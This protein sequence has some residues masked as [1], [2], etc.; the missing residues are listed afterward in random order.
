[1]VNGIIKA[2]ITISY[3]LTTDARLLAYP[4]TGTIVSLDHVAQ[5]LAMRPEITGIGRV[6]AII[7]QPKYAAKSAV[8]AAASDL[9]KLVAAPPTTTL[10][11][12]SYS[13]TTQ[14]VADVAA[15]AKSRG[16]DIDTLTFTIPLVTGLVGLV[17]I[18]VAAALLVWSRPRTGIAGQ[19]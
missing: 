19:R 1:M 11:T 7:S 18:L 13:Q 15:F 5:A 8:T 6:L 9:A 2:P 16:D 12:T 17:L 4:K 14:S 3:L 10:F